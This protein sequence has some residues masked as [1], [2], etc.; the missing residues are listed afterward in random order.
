MKA[1]A[2]QFWWALA[3]IPLI[4]L[5][6]AGCQASGATHTLITETPFYLDGPQQA[7]PA[8]GALAAGTRVTLLQDAGSY[9]QV[10][11]PDGRRAYVSTDR[12][13]PLR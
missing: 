7:R 9:A 8:D 13:K 12:L 2:L 3:L 10:L 6:L 5:S 1:T 4:I 11:L